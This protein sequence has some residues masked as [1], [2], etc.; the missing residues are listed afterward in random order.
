MITLLK[1]CFCSCNSSNQL[2]DIFLGK[3]SINRDIII[4]DSYIN[5]DSNR[6]TIEVR[7]KFSRNSK[8]FDEG[9][10]ET[11][12]CSYVNSNSYQKLYWGYRTKKKNC[13]NNSNDFSINK[14]PEITTQD[15]VQKLKGMRTDLMNNLY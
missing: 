14:S 2:K 10:N 12:T 1:M 5:C 13:K 11:S 9:E 6:N 4:N 8:N 7:E 3:N 15:Y